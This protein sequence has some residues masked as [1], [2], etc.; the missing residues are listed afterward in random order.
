MIPDEYHKKKN[1]AKLVDTVLY[2][3]VDPS[4]VS[5][6]KSSAYFSKALQPSALPYTKIVIN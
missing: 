4:A 3:S 1:T 2:C 5:L 6:P